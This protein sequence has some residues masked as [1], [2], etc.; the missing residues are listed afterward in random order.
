MITS[1][2]DSIAASEVLTSYTAGC[3]LNEPYAEH[4]HAGV[5]EVMLIE[6]IPKVV[7]KAATQRNLR[8]G[9]VQNAEA[10]DSGPC[11]H[12]PRV[13]KWVGLAQRVR[14][15]G[16]HLVHDLMERTCRVSLRAP[17]PNRR[18]AA[19]GK[20]HDDRP[21]N[22]SHDR[23]VPEKHAHPPREGEAGADT[24][25]KALRSAR[26]DVALTDQAFCE[27]GAFI[28]PAALE[29]SSRSPPGFAPRADFAEQ[30]LRELPT[31]DWERPFEGTTLSHGR[32][33]S[34]RTNR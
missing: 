11:A 2:V 30:A 1:S 29:P 28:E 17:A 20:L 14:H 26:G 18:L 27:A 13:A 21:S 6:L 23:G 34:R 4:V 5:D 7:P 32:I 22:T 25:M 31:G 9:E 12:Q 3:S 33:V 8:V 24:T 15:S 10:L 19:V 16:E